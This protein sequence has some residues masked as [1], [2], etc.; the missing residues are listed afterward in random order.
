MNIKYLEYLLLNLMDREEEGNK[1]EFNELCDLINVIQT[2][3]KS[4]RDLFTILMS[5]LNY[6]IEFS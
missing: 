6:N 3:S 1:I 5:I 4:K 2:K